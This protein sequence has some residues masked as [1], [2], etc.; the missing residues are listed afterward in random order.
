MNDELREMLREI[1]VQNRK[2]REHLATIKYILLLPFI[3]AGV[4]FGISILAWI[5]ANL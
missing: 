2:Q 3:I 5:S 1:W 4:V